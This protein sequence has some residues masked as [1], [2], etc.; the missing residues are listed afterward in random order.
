MFA[1]YLKIAIRNLLRQKVHSSINILG[2]AIGLTCSMVVFLWVQDELS[3]DRFNEKA[4]DL[5]RVVETQRYS[6][7]QVFH[8]AVTPTAL[9]SALKQEIPEIAQSTRFSFNSLTVRHGDNVFTEGVAMVDSGFLEMFTLRF[10]E[11]NPQTALTDPHSLVLTRDAAT[12]YFGSEDPLGKVLIVNNQY[13]FAVTGVIENIPHN[14][15]L[16]YELLAPFLFAGELGSSMND[17][18]TNW[19]YTYVLFY[20]DVPVDAV[21]KKVINIIGQHAKSAT[22]VSLQPVTDIHLYSAGKYAADI[23]GLGDIEYVRIFSGIALFIL[24]IACANF[25]NLATARSERRAK[26]V[27]LRKVIGANRYHLILQFFGESMLMTLLAFVVAVILIELILPEFNELSGKTL[28]LHELNLAAVLGFLC[29]ALVAGL[30]AG[31]YPALVLSSFQPAETMKKGKSLAAG[32]SSFRKILVVTQFMLSIIMIIGT[33]VVSRQVDYIRHK[34]LGLN[35]ENVGYVWMSAEFRARDEIAKREL[36]NNGGITSITLINQLPTNIVSASSGWD[37]EG[38]PPDANVL[39]NFMSVDDDFAKTFQMQMA[40]GRFFSSS[41]AT[42]SLAAVVNETAAKTMG[43]ESPI[44]QRLKGRGKNLT[45]IGVV[46]DFNFKSIRTKIEPLVLLRTPSQ[47]YAMV[48]RTKSDGVAN[49]IADIE[50]VYREFNPE[51]P[52]NFNFLN[53]DYDHLYKSEERVGRI[54]EYFTFLAVFIAALGLYGLVSFTTER[55][56]KEIG[57]RKVLGATTSGL[58][59]LL[60]R[61]FVLLT[62]VANAIGWPV[63]Y[64]FA[65]GWLQNYAYHTTLSPGVFLMSAGLALVIVLVTVGYRAVRSSLANPVDALRYE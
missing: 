30:V 37:W 21:A 11:G 27:G 40:A 60:T 22:E 23:G 34:N 6:G 58:F 9:A 44:G 64:Y 8:V 25:M 50:K 54:S 47:Y 19:C 42:D 49:T 48:I 65:S 31:S 59:F 16:Q 61:E 3:F 10:L 24:L 38:K 13:N 26:E 51:T 2:L 45:I 28:A 7:G 12:K 14:S 1:N 35:K 63:A 57:V 15:H 5:Y 52:F 29:I 43:M 55:R 62:V 39:M 18:N 32:G 53:D 36:L 17:W 46:K 33:L 41:M 20:R 56:T 4:A